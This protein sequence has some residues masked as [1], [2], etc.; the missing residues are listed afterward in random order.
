MRFAVHV[1]P[2]TTHVRLAACECAGGDL[3]GWCEK[4]ATRLCVGAAAMHMVAVRLGS[5][6]WLAGAY[7]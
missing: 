4:V 2:L 5:I 7:V 6:D 3:V 1:L